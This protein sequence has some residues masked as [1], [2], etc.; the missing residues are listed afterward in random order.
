[1]PDDVGNALGVEVEEEQQ[2][3]DPIADTGVGIDQ[4]PADQ[5]GDR[6]ASRGRT[7]RTVRR[8]AISTFEARRYRSARRRNSRAWRPAGGP[9]SH[10]STGAWLHAAS[11]V[12]WAWRKSQELDCPADPAPLG[13]DIAGFALVRPLPGAAKQ[14]PDGE[15]FDQVA[16]DGIGNV[17][18]DT[19][20]P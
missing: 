9:A 8:P 19:G 12:S 11:V 1:M 18:Y 5:A 7:D 17:A 3:G 13:A 6:S 10:R 4:K 2:A 20:D 16:V 14:T 15:H